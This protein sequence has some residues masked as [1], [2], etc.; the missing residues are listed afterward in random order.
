[1]ATK[2]VNFYVEM[3]K[4]RKNVQDHADRAASVPK[5]EGIKEVLEETRQYWQEVYGDAVVHEKEGVLTSVKRFSQSFVP[6]EKVERT[7]PKSEEQKEFWRKPKT[8][9]EWQEALEEKFLKEAPLGTKVILPSLN[10]KNWGLT[11]HRLLGNDEAGMKWEYPC[12][13]LIERR[14]TENAVIEDFLHLCSGS[15]CQNPDSV[16][17]QKR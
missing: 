13:C 1:M 7:S 4:V 11:V 17:N 3:A 9:E 16:F 15:D 10:R 8:R 14:Q 12:G 6:P 2:E 5:E